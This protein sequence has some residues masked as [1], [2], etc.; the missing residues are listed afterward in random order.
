[1]GNTESVYILFYVAALQIV[2]DNYCISPKFLFS[3]WT[4]P[5]LLQPTPSSSAFKWV[6]LYWSLL[7]LEYSPACEYPWNV[8]S[9]VTTNVDM[10]WAHW[11]QDWDDYPQG[12]CKQS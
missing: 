9:E 4:T 7:I 3:N 6:E 8:G 10:A 12:L 11:A 1:M 5:A 2:Q